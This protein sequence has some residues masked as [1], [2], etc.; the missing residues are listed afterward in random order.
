MDKVKFDFF[1]EH[2]PVSSLSFE[3]QGNMVGSTTNAG[4]SNAGEPNIGEDKPRR[5]KPRRRT[6]VG[7]GQT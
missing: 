7:E 4:E 5:D 2:F 1:V 6:N 3:S